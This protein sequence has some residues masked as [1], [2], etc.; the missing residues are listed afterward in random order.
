MITYFFTAAKQAHQYMQT[1]TQRIIKRR[2]MH[3]QSTDMAI[4]H[5]LHIDAV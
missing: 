2:D 5:C 1:Y 3:T 4:E